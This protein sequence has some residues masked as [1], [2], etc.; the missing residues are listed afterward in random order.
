MK[1]LTKQ[2]NPLSYLFNPC[3]AIFRENN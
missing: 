1:S 2:F 3:R